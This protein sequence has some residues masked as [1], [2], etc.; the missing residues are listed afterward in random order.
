MLHPILQNESE[1][2][3]TKVIDLNFQEEPESWEDEAD[4]DGFS[5]EVINFVSRL[6]SV[7]ATKWNISRLSS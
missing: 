6:L 4:G 7:M 3:K 2:R 1:G 5:R